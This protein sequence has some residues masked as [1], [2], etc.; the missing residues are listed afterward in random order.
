[1]CLCS[2]FL[3]SSLMHVGASLFF[4]FFLQLR[5]DVYFCFRFSLL[6]FILLFSFF[7]RC[8]ISAT[9]KE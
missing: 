8:K 2:E 5:I 7:Y 9:S 6:F 3:L 1:M 4:F